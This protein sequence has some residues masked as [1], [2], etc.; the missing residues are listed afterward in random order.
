MAG[1]VCD[2]ARRLSLSG[3]TGSADEDGGDGGLCG[4]KGR[5]PPREGT[6]ATPSSAQAEMGF[7]NVICGVAREWSEADETSDGRR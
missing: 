1:P 6:D 2:V 5:S 4:S 3:N 7:V